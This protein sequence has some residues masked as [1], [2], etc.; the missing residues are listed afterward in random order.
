MKLFLMR[1]G[2]VCLPGEPREDIPVPAYLIE[3]DEG[4]YILVDTG[5]AQQVIGEY[6]GP[7]NRRITHRVGEGDAVEQQL[8]LLGLEAKDIR[9]VVCSHFDPDHAG[10]LASF[11][12]AEI[13]VQR[14]LYQAAIRGEVPRFE[15][16][17]AQWDAA[18][19]RFV[20]VDGDTQLV[21]GV[22]LVESSGHVPGHQSVLVR[23]PQMGA[24][25]L[26]I[27]ALPFQADSDPETRSIDPFDLDEA[28]VRESMRKLRALE[29]SEGVVLTVYG[30]DAEQWKTLKLLPH[31]Y[32]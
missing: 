16:T 29:R 3:T 25:L 10:H 9:Y 31:F 14:R 24:V 13:F 20:L 22:S 32:E 27:D 2:T 8:A 23:L 6:Q 18:G 19:L 1:V 17:R 12:G 30:H 21:P 26:A 7:G 5:L 28:K 15:V 11:V 4:T